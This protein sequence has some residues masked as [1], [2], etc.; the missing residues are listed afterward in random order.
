MEEIKKYFNKKVS[1][2]EIDNA[3]TLSLPANKWLQQAYTVYSQAIITLV[4]DKTLLKQKIALGA[5][6]IEIVLPYIERDTYESFKDDIEVG[7]NSQRDLD[8][9]L[10]AHY[11]ILP[12][13][14][15]SFSA[16]IEL[17]RSPKLVMALYARAVLDFFSENSDEVVHRA[18]TIAVIALYETFHQEIEDYLKK[19]GQRHLSIQADKEQLHLFPMRR[20]VKEHQ[21]KCI[22]VLGYLDHN[23]EHTQLKKFK[24]MWNYAFQIYA[25]IPTRI[26]NT[27]FQT[28]MAQCHKVEDE[29]EMEITKTQFLDSFKEYMIDKTHQYTHK[30]RQQQILGVYLTDKDQKLSVRSLLIGL[31]DYIWKEPINFLFIFL[32]INE[33]LKKLPEDETLQKLA[34]I[35][36]Y[37]VERYGTT[38]QEVVETEIGEETFPFS[39]TDFDSTDELYRDLVWSNERYIKDYNEAIQRIE[40]SRRRS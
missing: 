29:L 33:S 23:G 25:T 13:G 15:E 39:V 11:M 17:I 8:E 26:E 1:L 6:L 36:Y 38:F 27:Q 30:V 24:D 21:I 37:L 35:I 2:N 9:I 16:T 31:F 7:D 20:T 14:L 22:Q 34:V 28:Y 32:T 18:N 19:Q 4:Q 10:K 12:F 3:I 40:L 5:S